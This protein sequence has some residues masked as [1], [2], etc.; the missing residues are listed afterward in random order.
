MIFTAFFQNANDLQW[1]HRYY[2]SHFINN[3]YI[4][5]FTET[6]SSSFSFK[7]YITLPPLL[8]LEHTTTMSLS[9]LSHRQACKVVLE[10]IT[11]SSCSLQDMEEKKT[12]RATDPLLT[13][14]SSKHDKWLT[15][16]FIY[17]HAKPS[18][19]KILIGKNS[20]LT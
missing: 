12:S 7:K 13:S 19:A 6:L 14:S 16:I 10:G 3:K 5:Y 17:T 2:N 15:A 18:L 11:W 4:L 8:L 9:D 1:R 20:S